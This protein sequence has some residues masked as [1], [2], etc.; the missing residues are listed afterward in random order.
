M[1]SPVVR[2]ALV[3]AVHIVQKTAEIPLETV[4]LLEV[5]DM[6]VLYIDWCRGRDRAVNCG[7]P[8]LQCFDRWL[9]SLFCR[10]SCR[11]NMVMAAGE[12]AMDRG[13]AG[14]GAQHTGDELM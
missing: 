11:W 13:L 6:P 10:S 2:A 1:Y 4:Q 5:V 7:V 14:V 8:Q 3:S 12:T 9:M